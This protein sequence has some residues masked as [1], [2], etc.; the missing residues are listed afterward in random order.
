MPPDTPAPDIPPGLT[1]L[2]RWAGK[3]GRTPDYVRIFWRARPG[4]PEP[5]GT[6]P[7]RDRHGG[8]Q[9]EL[10][11]H[12]TCLDTWLAAQ[13]D[14]QPP[15][16]IDLAAVQGAPD[17]RVTL[18]RFA[19]VIGK[20]RKTVTQHRDRPGFPPPGPDRKYSLADLLGYWNTRTGRADQPGTNHPPPQ[21]ATTASRELGG[22]CPAP[23]K[24]F[25][26]WRGTL[27]P[28]P[29]CSAR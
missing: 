7:A 1:T 11:F 5:A 15:E 10:L 17:E 9:G 8:G 22:A 4:F 6:L 16:R 26:S 28:D 2:R 27:R 25:R 24:A 21:E 19:A 20:D 23:G 12:E 18:G 29:R 14:L 3:H 13:P